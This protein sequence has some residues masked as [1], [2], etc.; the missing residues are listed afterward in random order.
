MPYATELR[1]KVFRKTIGITL[2]QNK[3]VSVNPEDELN[4]RKYLP[5][6]SIRVSN[7][8][9]EDLQI[10]VNDGSGS[11]IVPLKSITT[12]DEM[13]IRNCIIKN[14]SATTTSANEI[15]VEFQSTSV[16]PNIL[17]EALGKNPLVKLALGIR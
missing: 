13:P 5:F 9:D 8:S 10:D 14:I 2:A 17:S 15:A 16:T 6:G 4:A 11:F 3:R 7:N 1:G 12:Y